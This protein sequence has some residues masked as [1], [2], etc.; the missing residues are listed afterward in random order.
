MDRLIVLL[1][2][3]S[4]QDCCYPDK[5]RS[6]PRDNVCQ[7]RSEGHLTG[8]PNGIVISYAYGYLR[9][10]VSD[11]RVIPPVRFVCIQRCKVP[12]SV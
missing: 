7:I 8:R 2:I 10:I 1:L 12:N 5:K 4:D 11:E 6:W 3:T 9:L